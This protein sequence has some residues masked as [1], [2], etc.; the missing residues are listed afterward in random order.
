M[1]SR[2]CDR[3]AR[4]EAEIRRLRIQAR[5]DFDEL[6]DA[7]SRIRVLRRAVY[8]LAKGTDPPEEAP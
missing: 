3:C 7:Q 8:K 1:S 6:E 5:R 2:D 4:L